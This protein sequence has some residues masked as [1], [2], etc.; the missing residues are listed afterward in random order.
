MTLNSLIKQFEGKI[1]LGSEF[2][3]EGEPW[4]D[5]FGNNPEGFSPVG[6]KI[7]KAE[8]GFN[9]SREDAG[10]LLTFEGWNEPFFFYDND[11]LKLDVQ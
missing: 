5:C 9:D 4:Y 3:G 6:A 7:V 1:F 2:H 11:D 10:L 8:I